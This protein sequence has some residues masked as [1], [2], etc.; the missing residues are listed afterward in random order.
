MKKEIIILRAKSVIKKLS[1]GKAT[2]YDWLNKKSPRY[3][4]DFPKKVNLGGIVGW[5]EHEIDLWIESKRL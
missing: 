4:P 2:L 5:I 3:K 1:I